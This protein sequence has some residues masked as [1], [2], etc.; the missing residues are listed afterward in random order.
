MGEPSHVRQAGVFTLPT[1]YRACLLLTNL[2][3]GA[4]C[5]T[6][7]YK[8]DLLVSASDSTATSTDAMTQGSST[9]DVTT[10]SSGSES[11]SNNSTTTSEMCGN[12]MLEPPEDCDDGNQTP[13]DG[14]EPN[15]TVTPSECGDGVKEG[16]EEC[17]DGNDVNT[18]DCIDCA[19]AKCGDGH[20]QIGVEQCDDGANNGQYDSC[21]DDCSGPG[22][23][24]GDGAVNGPEDCD[25]GNQVDEDDCSNECVAPRYVFV[26]ASTFTGNLG[27]LAGADEK[28]VISG[29]TIDP[30]ATWVAWLSDSTTPASMRLDN[31]FKGYYRLPGMDK[32]VIAKGWAGLTSGTLLAP[33]NRTQAGAVVDQKLSVWTNTTVAGTSA[34]GSDDCSMWTSVN[35]FGRSGTVGALDAIWTDS[36]TLTCI[37]TLRLYCFQN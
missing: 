17:D 16:A 13:G 12:G 30:N 27:G 7:S 21:A 20:V 25:D 14:C 36:G 34:V 3:L 31:T 29:G 2:A 9:T 1:G 10:S 26:T 32:P 15:C 37:S 19:L 24:C 35:N 33:I 6:G 5:L 22:P 23:R 11:G 4:G 28:C 18:D 8:P